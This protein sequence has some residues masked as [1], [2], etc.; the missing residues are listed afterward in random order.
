MRRHTLFHIKNELKISLICRVLQHYS[1]VLFLLTK[2]YFLVYGQLIVLILR[3]R[4]PS[5]RVTWKL[6]FFHP[7]VVIHFLMLFNESSFSW[8]ARTNDAKSLSRARKLRGKSRRSHRWAKVKWN[9]VKNIYD[10]SQNIG[11][12]MRLSDDCVDMI[13]FIDETS[14]VALEQFFFFLTMKQIDSRTRG[15]LL[16]LFSGMKIKWNSDS[17]DA[18]WG[19]ETAGLRGNTRFTWIIFIFQ[20]SAEK[21]RETSSVKKRCI[22]DTRKSDERAEGKIQIHVE[23]FGWD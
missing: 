7:H 13:T 11:S 17:S 16:L 15:L 20:E 2:S 6:F 5:A 1:V 3:Q 23:A 18:L 14:T 19:V 12:G 4:V 9:C 8:R 22:K 21:N 10:N